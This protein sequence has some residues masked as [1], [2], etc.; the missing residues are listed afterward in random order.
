MNINKSNEHH[1]Y[2]ICFLTTALIGGGAQRV[3]VNVANE[4]AKDGYDVHIVCFVTKNYTPIYPVHPSIKLHNVP[5]E[6]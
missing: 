1:K 4:F 5:R 6:Y 2:K 3:M